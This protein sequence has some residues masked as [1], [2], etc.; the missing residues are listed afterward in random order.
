MESVKITFL[1]FLYGATCQEKKTFFQSY[2]DLLTVSKASTQ[3]VGGQLGLRRI[4]K[5][6]KYENTHIS[7]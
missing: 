2:N 3:A 7:Y 5:V 6:L 4:N 1:T